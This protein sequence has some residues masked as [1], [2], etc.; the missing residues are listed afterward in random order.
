MARQQ[1][2][3]KKTDSI[4]GDLNR[5]HDEISRQAYD[6]FRHHEGFLTSALEDWL[7]AERDLVWQPAIELR[8]TDGQFE[9]EAAVAGV[10]PRDLNVQVAPEDIL[11]TARGE[12]HHE[13]KRGTV[14]VCEFAAG[15][16]FRSVHLPER[17]DPDSVKAE[18]RNGLLRLTAAVARPVTRKV[19]IQAA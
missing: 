8:Q 13:A 19:D 18:L 14:H 1:I 17:I 11:I 5:L 10:D 9:L 4:V 7:R 12:H 6:L 16:L 2:E 15:R 3:L